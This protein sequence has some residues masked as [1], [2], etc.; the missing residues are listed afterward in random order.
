[1]KQIFNPIAMG[2]PDAVRVSGISRS[3]IYNA[4]KRGELR[5]IKAGKRTLITVSDLQA[6]LG[7]LPRYGAE[8]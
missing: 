6:Y 7:A 3:A 4:L 8:A 1:M 2:I 5:A